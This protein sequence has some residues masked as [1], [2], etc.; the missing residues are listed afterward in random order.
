[1]LQYRKKFIIYF[2]VHVAKGLNLICNL[3]STLMFV[4]LNI[5]MS[6]FNKL[7]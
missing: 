7:Y 2:A 5:Q 3:L 1:M 6:T 4:T